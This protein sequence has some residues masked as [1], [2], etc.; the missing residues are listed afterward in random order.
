MNPIMEIRRGIVLAIGIGSALAI[1]LLLTWALR[2]DTLNTAK[3]ELLALILPAARTATG[4]EKLKL[5]NIPGA[6]KVLA[7]EKRVIVDAVKRASENDKTTWASAAQQIDEVA[8]SRRTIR[9]ELDDNNRRLDDQAAELVRLKADREKLRALLAKAD[10][11]REQAQKMLS[12]INITPAMEA[13]ALALDREA[14]KAQDILR[15][16]GI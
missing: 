12:A 2:L 4:D 14:R 8:K 15:N 10:A 11:R 13:D 7:D 6:L 3:R 9:L 1:A 16:A 5:A